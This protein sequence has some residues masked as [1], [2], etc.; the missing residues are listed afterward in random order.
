VLVANYKK[1]QIKRHP[2][3][4]IERTYKLAFN[5][6]PDI[7]S[8]SNLIEKIYWMELY[9]DLSL[10]T[11][12][13]DKYLVRD[14]VKE[15]DYE[16]YLPKLLGKWDK[17]DLFTVHGLP[18]KFIIKTNNGCGTCIP[19]TDKSKINEAD[20]RDK[21]DQWLE[22]PY[23][24]SNS[25]LHYLKI[26]RCIIAEEL[27]END[28]QGKR[29]SPNSLIDYKVWC[30]NGRVESVLVVY[31]RRN[32]LYCLD[33][34]DKNWE[35]MKNNLRFNGHFEFRETPIPCPNCLSE[36]FEIAEKL[37]KPF[38]QVRVDFYV[39]NNRPYI[40]ELTLATGY[41][42]FTE[43]YYQYL[44]EKIDISKIKKANVPNYLSIE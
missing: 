30:I 43:E 14:Y 12:C 10:W 31:D 9:A 29:F 41:G 28:D 7:E 16:S 39:L 40:G 8:P 37:A 42:Y 21:L 15:C 18:E 35:R 22:I 23:G 1:N 44:G 3:K 6:K 38:P 17:A 34:Y 26:P 25:Q 5:K 20:V 36:M 27:L 13:A 4:E 19:V 33:L 32:D 11:K 24:Y 2:F